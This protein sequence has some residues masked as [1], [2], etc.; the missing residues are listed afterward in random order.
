MDQNTYSPSLYYLCMYV[1]VCV[2]ASPLSPLQIQAS[3]TWRRERSRPQLT[4][5]TWTRCWTARRRPRRTMRGCLPT[6]PT[7][8]SSGSSWRVSRACTRRCVWGV[9]TS[10]NAVGIH[11]LSEVCLCV[12]GPQFARNTSV[13]SQSFIS[14]PSPAYIHISAIKNTCIK[15][16]PTFSSCFVFLLASSPVLL[17]CITSIS[18]STLSRSHIVSVSSLT[19]HRHYIASPFTYN[20]SVPYSLV[21]SM[22]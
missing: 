11:C 6:T 17:C 13:I 7:C 9:I 22:P 1:C 21:T 5:W 2:H 16:S 15:L 3:G 14:V 8:T 18:P 10:A 20:L 12:Y 19:L 4:P